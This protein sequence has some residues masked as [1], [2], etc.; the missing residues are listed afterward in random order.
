MPFL[1]ARKVSEKE[2]VGGKGERRG[3]ALP[4]CRDK[5]ALA[6]RQVAVKG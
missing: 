2:F 3:G 5:R 1:P 6:A 4:A